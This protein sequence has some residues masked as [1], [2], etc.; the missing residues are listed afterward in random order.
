[1]EFDGFAKV[2]I[3]VQVRYKPAMPDT[4]KRHAF[5][6]YL[7]AAQTLIF[8]REG[9]IT[10]MTNQYTDIMRI[11]T[12]RIRKYNAKFIRD[13]SELELAG[14]LQLILK[15][16]KYQPLQRSG[17]QPF[18]EFLKRKQA[19]INIRN[20]NERCFSFSILYF[21]D[22]P[23]NPNHLERPI[24][25]TEEMFNRNGL[26]SLPYPISPNDVQFY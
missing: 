10:A 20:V 9:T 1:M 3:T 2:W 21:I 22:R 19:I 7:S 24:Y 12:E 26:D 16:S 6:Q 23:H 17:W 18:P 13:K 8:K 11:L 5:D 25:I 14:I 4:D 15:M